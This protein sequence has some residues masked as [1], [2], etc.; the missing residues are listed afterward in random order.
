MFVSERLSHK[1]E[2]IARLRSSLSKTALDA[3]EKRLQSRLKERVA[4][5]CVPPRT[6][7]GPVCLS[8]PQQGMWIADQLQPGTPVYNL[9][10]ALRLTGRLDQRALKSSLDELVR[11][12]E[13]LRTRFTQIGGEPFQVVSDIV[14][15]DLRVD[16]LTGLPEE[17]RETEARRITKD[18]SYGPFDL[19]AGPMFRTRL[20]KLSD[21]DHVLIMVLHHSVS[22]L[23]SMGIVLRELSA[24]Y[25][26]YSR[27]KTSPLPELPIQYPD[28]ALWQRSYLQ[29]EVLEDHLNYWK[30]Q[31]NGVPATLE[32]PTDYSR[33]P[34]LSAS[35]AVEKFIL[36]ES[37][38]EKV[39]QLSREQGATLFMT[40]LAAF[41][42]LLSRYSGQKDIVVG[43]TSAGRHRAEL[44]G[45]IGAFLNTLAMRTNF[46]DDPTFCQLLSRVK[47]VCLGAYAHQD[48][49]FER[50]VAEVQPERRSNYSPIFQ[51]M[52][53]L[54]SSHEQRELQGADWNGLSVSGFSPKAEKSMFD[55]SFRIIEAPQTLAATIEYSTDLFE[56]DTIKRMTR[57]FRVL[58]ASIV[59]HPEVPIST[60]SI[61]SEA[62]SRELL[63]K[64]NDTSTEY[65]T[66]L[67]IHE[68]FE[69]QAARTPESIALVY[70]QERFSYRELNERA[71][72]LGHYLQQRGV[73]PEAVVGILLERSP[74]MVIALLATLKAG[75]AYLPLDPGYPAERLQL[76]L[77]DSG[78]RVLLTTTELADKLG[79]TGP[80]EV[81]KLDVAGPEL[82]QQSTANVPQQATA[83]NLAYVIYT[84]GSTGTPKAA[85]NTHGAIRNRL[86]WMQEAFALSPDDCVLQK[87]PYSFDVSVWEFFWPL[88]Y[89]A[90]LAVAR[91]EGHKDA[92]YLRE[93]IAREG[94]TTLHFVPSML[95]VFLP[96]GDFERCRSVRQVLCSG[97][98][99]SRELVEQF[100]QHLS[101]AR[102]HNLYGPT[103]AAVDVSYWDCSA[104]LTEA[105][106]VPIG[107]PIANT[108]LY[109]LGE[110]LQPVG[111]KTPGELY[112]GGVGVGRGYWQRPQLTAERFIPDP[113]GSQ[114]GARLYRTGDRARYRAD[115]KLEFLGRADYQV[116]LRGQR[117]ELGEI[118]VALARHPLIKNAAVVAREDSP[119]DKRLVAYIIPAAAD[120]DIAAV[121]S[122]LGTCLPDYMVPAAFVKLDSFPLSPSGKLDRKALPAP[123]NTRANLS[124]DFVAPRSSL[125]Q[126]LADIWTS[127]LGV[128]QIGI[129]DNFFELGGHSLLLTQL[130]TRI[131]DTFGVEIPMRVLFD[132]PT[133]EGISISI[134]LQL[135]ESEDAE[136]AALL[137]EMGEMIQEETIA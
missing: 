75:G 35:G 134:S 123:D 132:A 40:L 43:C 55:L 101:W 61:L 86:L 114:S 26:A 39:K 122:F 51:V 48:L 8:F 71:N 1:Q 102:L 28:F 3:L 37:L 98:A 126:E 47:E 21:D 58:L 53:S 117:I 50:L 9:P 94:V 133:I 110:Q 100:F 14:D 137:A 91:P 12:H 45:L 129:Y 59:S 113:H 118:E 78:T 5:D 60:L 23:W 128:K 64:W 41:K 63:Q 104:S 76:M 67:L 20:L 4:P 65:A 87:T 69:Q 7:A 120:L 24:L 89:G 90:R 27:D 107:V 85:M 15:L 46:S 77:A 135:V 127:V 52:F 79:D 42:V 72:R 105:G 92:E 84:S 83:D 54:H 131:R 88:M 116:K 22:D 29:G 93:V 124:A 108:Q 119:G 115:G 68:L 30:R 57:H 136:L 97:E 106:L 31:L 66:D 17:S 81:I 111:I 73:G 125:E 121:R 11:R 96:H 10:M 36:P 16:D 112:I 18:E 33:P 70:E 99:L 109:V 13:S 32:L 25:N 130:G 82:A 49:P 62:E 95:S 56:A 80:L 34:R 38:S 19:T 74:E 103:E 2:Q 6:Q 44:E